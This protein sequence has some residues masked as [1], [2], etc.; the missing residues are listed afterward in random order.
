MSERARVHTGH[1]F[2]HAAAKGN[3]VEV[4]ALGIKHAAERAAA[5]I[6]LGET[7][8]RRPRVIRAENP[9]LDGLGFSVRDPGGRFLRVLGF[10][11]GRSPWITLASPRSRQQHHAPREALP[12]HAVAARRAPGWAASARTIHS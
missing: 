4:V 10:L 8:L 7:C 3:H 5:G 6:V 11:R 2:V 12:V 1:T 9:V